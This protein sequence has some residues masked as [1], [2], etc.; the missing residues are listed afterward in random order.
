MQSLLKEIRHSP[1]LWM[2]VFVPLVL[3]AEKAAPEAHTLLFVLAVLAIVP[4]AA[5][6]SHATEAV[7]AKTGDAV[8]GLL[9]AT[10]GNLTELIIAV[11]A[12]HAGQYMLVKASIAG[13]IVTNALFMLGACLLLG[14]LRYHV[15]EF[16]RAGGRLYSG[17]LLM[18]TVAL[19]A[20]SA[21]ADLDL[22]HGE[23]IMQKLSVG[24]AVLLIIAYAL[25]LLF[26]LGTHKELFASAEHGEGEEHW[27]I[28]VAVGTLLAVTVLVALVSEIFVESVQKAAETFGMS[29]AFVGFIIVSLVGAAAEFAVAFSAARKDRLDMSVSIALGS[30]SQIALFVAP[31]LVLLSYVVGPSPMSLQFWPGAVTMVMIATVTASFITSSGRS[32]WFI[33]AL[34]IFIYAVFAL[35]LYVVPPGTQGPG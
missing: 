3:V 13:A 14:G 31:A 7:A 17:L 1:L 25:G 11:T 32:A 4:L 34:L 26:S 35:T 2:L 16:N 9:N 30:A 5:L 22:A 10:L 8:G 24:L 19:L 29:P 20:P 6:L 21:V 12:L 28:G 18:A 33:G 15:Q 23:A 27:P